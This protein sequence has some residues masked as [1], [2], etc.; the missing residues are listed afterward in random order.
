MIERAVCLRG[1]W[2]VGVIGDEVRLSSAGASEIGAFP[3]GLEFVIS[4]R[5][6][7]NGTFVVAAGGEIDLYTAPELERVLAGPL[8]EGTARLV[9]DLS[10]ATFVDSTALHVFLRAARQ[11]DR[12]A[13]E[14]IVVVPDPNVRKVFEITGVDRF[15]SVVSS[16]STVRVPS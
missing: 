15:L 5:R 14:L 2:R 13:G 8:A 6:L 3:P 7:A 12:E 10:E 1:R 9:V 16:L 11:L 4:S